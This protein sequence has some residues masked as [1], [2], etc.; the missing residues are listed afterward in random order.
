VRARSALVA[1]LAVGAAAG[2]STDPGVVVGSAAGMPHCVPPNG[3]AEG[4]T[5]VLAQSVPT[6][7]WLPCVREVPVGWMF[8]SYLPRDGQTSIRFA[9]DRDGASALTVLLRPSC[10][11]S[12][13]TEV[14]SEQPEMRR[15]E[16][17]TRVST[18]YGGERHYT[19]TG[20]CIT[21]QFDL[22]GNTR[23]EP[24]ATIS[25]SL[26]FLSRSRLARQVHDSSDGRLELDLRRGVTP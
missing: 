4:G 18:G 1:L 23:A 10:D 19:F 24:V 2:C 26:G 7:Q 9:S 6:A 21:Y 16:R 8:V 25:E 22:R 14:P 20:G 17:V 3:S 11:L 12:G 15:Y 5:V 13:A